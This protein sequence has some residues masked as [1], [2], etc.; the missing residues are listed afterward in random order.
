MSLENYGV[1]VGQFTRFE[2]DDPD[3]AG[4]YYHGMVFVDAPDPEGETVTYRCAVDVNAYNGP[5]HYLKL[6]IKNEDL[7]TVLG[8][9][10]GYYELP[11]TGSSGAIDYQRS[12]FISTPIGCAMIFNGLL[13]WLT[14]QEPRAVWTVAN[15]ND[16]LTALETV[17]AGAMRVI[18][19]G[20][21][22]LNQPS[23]ERGMHN[24]HMN[25]GNDEPTPGTP[26]YNQHLG[27]FLS[28]GIWQDGAVFVPRANNTTDA[29]LVHFDVQHLPTDDNGNPV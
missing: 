26:D 15:G 11:T 14:R 9:A 6:N 29:Y 2:R 5:I 8:L 28:N 17:L 13:A 16:A 20:E 7:A 1:L 19:F 24:V 12:D 10:P 23:G 21:P 3:N 27:W 25:Q 18:V 22:F 4:L